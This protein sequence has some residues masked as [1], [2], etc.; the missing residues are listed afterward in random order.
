ME[1]P[2]YGFVLLAIFLA[3]TI[4]ATEDAVYGQILGE[5]ELAGTLELLGAV[6]IASAR[7]KIIFEILRFVAYWGCLIL[8]NLLLKIMKLLIAQFQGYRG[9]DDIR[10][11]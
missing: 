2:Q 4:W 3:K 6:L 1:S 5:L 10:I 7:L 8:E 11:L 9:C